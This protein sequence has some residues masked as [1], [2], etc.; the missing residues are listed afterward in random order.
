MFKEEVSYKDGDQNCIAFVASHNEKEKRPAVV[1]CH[2]WA[3]RDD[4]ACNTAMKMT[5]MGYVGVALDIYGDKKIGTNTEENSALMNPFIEDRKKLIQRLEAGYNHVRSLS[6]VDENNI[7]AIGFCFGGLCALDMARS[8]LNLKGVVSFHGLLMAPDY[9][10]KSIKPK[11]LA[12]HGQEDPMVDMEKLTEFIN[13]MREKAEDWQLHSFGNTVHAFT[14][15]DANDPSF[16]TVY[17]ATAASRSFK[18]L[19]NFLSESFT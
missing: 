6:Y 15:P 10:V 14:N 16:G 5:E 2:A 7:A 13:E 1:I 18:M 12:L 4:F 17:S 11:V 9:E 8:N 19:E 3:G